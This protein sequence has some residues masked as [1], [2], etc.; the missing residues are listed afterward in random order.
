MKAAAVVFIVLE[1]FCV[2]A[3]YNLVSLLPECIMSDLSKYE[4]TWNNADAW[5]TIRQCV[6]WFMIAL[7]IIA[8]AV[9]AFILPKV[10]KKAWKNEL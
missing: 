5:I 2:V 1:I 3:V 9:D 7:V 10:I 4:F 8:C 6:G